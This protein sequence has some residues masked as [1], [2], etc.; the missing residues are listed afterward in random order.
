MIG[1]KGAISDMDGTLIDSLMLWNRI[2]EAF[3]IKFLHEPSFVPTKE[4]DKMLRT[5]T[6]RDGMCYV[7]DNYHIG[8]NGEDLL[9]FANTII[10][11]FYAHEV[12]L[13][14][15]VLNFLEYCFSNNVKMCI[16]SATE[17]NLIETAVAHCGIGKYFS[18]IFSC[19]E[20]GSGKDKPDIYLKALDFLGTKKEETY[21]F[22]DS[23]VAI[24]TANKIGMK[25]IGIYDKYNYGH[26]EMEKLATAYIAEGETLEKLIDIGALL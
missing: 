23:L 25:T 9:E 10:E 17:R 26:E 20:I 5:M 7:Y 8:R 6:L 18:N 16:A 1:M 21:I 11:N 24:N 4:D 12:K 22:E 2:W 3:G 15:G 14:N 19:A 13:K